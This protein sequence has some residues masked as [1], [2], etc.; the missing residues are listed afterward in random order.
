MCRFENVQMNPRISIFPYFHILTLR[1]AKGKLSS[2]FPI[3]TSA[4]QQISTLAHLHISTSPHFHIPISSPFDRLRAG[5]SHISPIVQVILVGLQKI[6][7]GKPNAFC[8]A[9]FA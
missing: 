6:F 7:H 1:Q 3:N 5:Y 9:S 4:H 8:P 2:H